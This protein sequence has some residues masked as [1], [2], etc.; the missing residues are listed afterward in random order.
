MFKGIAVEFLK[1]FPVLESLRSEQM[2]GYLG[3]VVPVQTISRYIYNLIN[4]ENYYGKP[5]LN[6]VR[7][8]LMAVHDHAV[9]NYVRQGVRSV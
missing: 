1:H 8:S 6:L 7:S 4:K 2:E 5:T 9:K 3:L